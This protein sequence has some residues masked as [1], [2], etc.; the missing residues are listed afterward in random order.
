[1]WLAQEQVQATYEAGEA[2]E[3][4]P[5]AGYDVDAALGDGADAA[6][7]APAPAHEGVEGEGERGEAYEEEEYA[8]GG[9]GGHR[10]EG[11]VLPRAGHAREEGPEA[12]VGVEGRELE[13]APEVLGVA[14]A[15]LDGPLYK[16][17]GVP[18][19]AAAGPDAREG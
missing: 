6:A 2:Y 18:V 8:E 10:L 4:H 14:L 13:R 16:V 7:L 11:A 15:G 12:G 1:M 17:E 19:L 9:G 5:Y 3:E